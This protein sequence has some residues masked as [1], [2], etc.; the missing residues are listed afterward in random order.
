MTLCIV[1]E[2]LFLSLSEPVGLPAC[3][4]ACL[5]ACLTSYICTYWLLCFLTLHPLSTPPPARACRRNGLD[6]NGLEWTRMDSN[7]LEWS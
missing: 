3:R 5:P 6:W 2:N 4:P 1:A 7:G